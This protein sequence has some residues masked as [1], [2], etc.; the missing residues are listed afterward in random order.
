MRWTGAQWRPIPVN[1]SPGTPDPN[2]L[3][4]VHVMQ[5]S[6]WGTDSWFR[7]PRAQASAHFGVGK[8][9]TCFQ[10]VDTDQMAWHAC[11]ANPFSIGVETEGYSGQ[12]F[13]NAQIQSLARMFHWAN[14]NYP[15][16]SMWLNSRPYTGSGLSWHG[17]GGNA[18]CG[19]PSCPGSARVNQL[20][21]ILSKAK[22]L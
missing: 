15:G 3:F 17:L 20:G 8:D 5:G 18:W 4:I 6:L 21:L 13:T 22:S 2:R 10:W 16:I 1:W 7:N 9:G 14:Q 12:P 11:D 19:H